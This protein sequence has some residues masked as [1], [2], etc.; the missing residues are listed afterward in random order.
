MLN[1]KIQLNP[2]IYHCDDPFTFNL[3]KEFTHKKNPNVFQ[4]TQPFSNHWCC[5]VATTRRIVQSHSKLIYTK[6]IKDRVSH[7]HCGFLG[8]SRCAR[9]HY[10]YV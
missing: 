5:N 8:T 6:Q 10:Y 1:I 7:H 3:S 4:F 2:F 9:H